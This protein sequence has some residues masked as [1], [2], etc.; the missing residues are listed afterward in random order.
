MTTNNYES[1][2]TTLKAIRSALGLVNGDFELSKYRVV[3]DGEGGLCFEDKSLGVDVQCFTFE[4]DADGSI[5][6]TEW[7]ESKLVARIDIKS[8][9]Q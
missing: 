9:Q 4:V 3:S 6:R 1:P 5:R 8:D 2:P 7:R